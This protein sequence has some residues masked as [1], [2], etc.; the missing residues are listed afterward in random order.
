MEEILSSIRRV[1]A[2]EDAETET[3]PARKQKAV[4][5]VTEEPFPMARTNQNTAADDVLEL[6]DVNAATDDAAL[7]SDDSASAARDSLSALSEAAAEARPTPKP[8]MAV[9]GASL[10]AMVRDMIR[11]MLKDWLDANLPQIV[12]DMVADE[13]ARIARKRG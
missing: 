7:V 5:S 13:I 12:E 9:G 11:P 3:V 2:R 8:D 10:D 6:S 4:E 1:M